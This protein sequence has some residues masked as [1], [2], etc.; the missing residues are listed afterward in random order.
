MYCNRGYVF[1]SYIVQKIESY[2][3]DMLEMCLVC[4]EKSGCVD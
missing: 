3:W 4:A 1:I 2:F